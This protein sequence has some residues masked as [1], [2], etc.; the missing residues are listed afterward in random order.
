M[1][2]SYSQ[3]V[4]GLLASTAY[5][6]QVL[7][8]NSAGNGPVSSPQ[9]V[10][11]T[12]PGAATGAFSVSAGKVF[13]PNGN[14]HIAK[15]INVFGWD[16]T[17]MSV[18]SANN[19][20]QPLTSLFPGLNHVRINS[21]PSGN[22]GTA[23]A[24]YPP[25]SLF[26][27]FV[28]QLTGYTLSGTTWTKTSNQNI[29]VEIEDHDSNMLQ[30]PFTGS[31]LT[32]QANW[33]ASLAAF[34]LGN[35]YVW[36]G[37]MNE[38]GAASYSLTDI[39]LGTTNHVA[40]YNAIRGTGSKAM[41]QVMAGVGGSNLGT[42][43][44]GAG[45]NVSAYASMTNIVWELH[46]YMTGD[47][48]DPYNGGYFSGA[49]GYVGGGTSMPLSGAAGGWGIIGA[50]TIQSKD[51]V[52]PVIIGE[53]GPGGD[54][55]NPGTTEGAPMVAKVLAV[56]SQNHGATAWGYYPSGFD[57]GNWNCVNQGYSSNPTLTTWGTQVASV[58]R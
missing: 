54:A 16:N 37:T 40:I 13:D 57:G 44:V 36:F 24:V 42:V 11:T 19:N 28:Q 49:A 53:W 43:G 45:W 21:G 52:V 33:Y 34:Y 25:P 56:Q 8:L 2:S 29:V 20:A 50:Q 41:L 3:T 22:N 35:P 32:A 31:I 46:C 26:L 38:M 1:A 58:V 17:M 39:G 6:F 51:G 12:A 7:A 15:G 4:T 18:A 10:A 5:D 30:N 48:P 9:V 27:T 14:V 47:Q 23:S 55:G